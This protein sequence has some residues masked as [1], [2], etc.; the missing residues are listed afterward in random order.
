MTWTTL[1]PAPGAPETN[2]LS[3]AEDQESLT[4]DLHTVVTRMIENREADGALQAKQLAFV[5]NLT[6]GYIEIAW[7]DDE[8]KKGL[9]R[10]LYSVEIKPL[11]KK[12]DGSFNLHRT[13]FFAI[14]DYM[15]EFIYDEEGNTSY[16]VFTRTEDGELEELCL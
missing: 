7:Y 11:W 16:D 15:E 12:I 1:D 8:T 2:F 14:C 5:M 4:R 3:S 13:C 6:N 10:C 9:G